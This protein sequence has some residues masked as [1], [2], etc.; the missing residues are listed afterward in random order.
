MSNT[1]DNRG[2]AGS[3]SLFP[4]R[5]DDPLLHD[6]D[7]DPEGRTGR[8]PDG[9]SSDPPAGDGTSPAADRETITLLYPDHDPSK[10]DDLTR[11]LNG[12]WRLESIDL[13][14]VKTQ[15]A[16]RGSRKAV[17][18]TFVLRRSSPTSLFE[19]S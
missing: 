12:D 13:D 18:V 5:E 19:L 7:E 8:A 14:A 3:S 4:S 15:R 6:A 1:P 16:E 17:Q 9:S 2:A 10:L 11:A